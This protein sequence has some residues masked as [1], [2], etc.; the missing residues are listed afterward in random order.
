MSERGDLLVRGGTVVDGTGA[1]P[2]RAD[3]RVRAGEVVE[4]AP[5][6]VPDG[7]TEVDATG[8]LVTPGLI[9]PHTHYDL[10]M[11]WDPTLDPLPSYGVTTV[12]MGNCGLGIA[13]ARDDVRD[14]VVDLMCF[15]EELPGSL[16]S[17]CVP[18]GWR[19][20]SEYHDVAAQTP[21]TVTPFAYVAHNALRAAAM[22]RDAWDREATDAEI[23][24]MAALLDDALAHGALGMSSNWFDTDRSRRLVPSRRSDT[25]EIDALLT[26]LARHPHTSFQLIARSPEDRRPLLERALA[27]G[28]RCLSLGD[29]VGGV[30]D[31]D[32]PVYRL[33]GGA[34]PL[35]PRLGF[36]SSI[37]AAAVP[38]WHQLING[39]AADKPRLLADPEWRA[40]ARHDWDHPLDEQNSFRAGT[41]HLLILSDSENGTGPVGISLQQLATDRGVHP[42]DALADWV[43]ANGIGSRYTKLAVRDMTQ[44]EMDERVRTAFADPFALIGGTDAGAHLKMFCGAGANL[45]VLTHWVRDAQ[46]VSIEHAVHCMTQRNAEFFSLHDRGV[47]APGRRGDL[48]VFSLDEIETR[49]YVRAEDLPERDWRYTRPSAGFRATIVGGVPTVLDGAPTGA[50]PTRIGDAGQSARR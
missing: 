39:P 46:E 45:Y 11:F 4:V 36:E 14:D 27:H 42:S 21:T 18:W 37:A 28:V 25:R 23:E 44:E 16:A 35:M 7:E 29:G 22:G 40:L 2:V 50:R 13:P 1:P 41:L 5:G 8:A 32:L 12:V 33:G 49:P 38:A 3:V 31:T 34:E 47:V 15:I 48:A 17:S 20:W 43:L 9:D 10:E 6:L 24:A 19:T 30:T 26:V